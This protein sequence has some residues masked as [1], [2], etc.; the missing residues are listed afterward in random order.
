M[1][2]AIADDDPVARFLLSATLQRLGHEVAVTQ[3]GREAWDIL[4]KE[5][6]PLLIADWIMPEIDGL[7]LCRLMRAENR[8]KY[9]YIILLTV[10]GGKGSFLEAMDAGADDFITK[11]HDADMLAARIRA[12]ERILRLQKE[13]KQLEGL[14]PICMYCKKIC[15]EQD[16]WIQME[17]YIT[18]RTDT[19][20]SHGFCPDCETV[21]K[22][23]FEAKGKGALL[24]GRLTPYP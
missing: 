18:H 13:V 16:R 23:E 8:T 12:A 1:R 5:E 21:A 6:V 4:R 22:A 9:T 10:M 24:L 14:L 3:N 17:S 2:I 7:E 20:F 19:L 11:P 15:D